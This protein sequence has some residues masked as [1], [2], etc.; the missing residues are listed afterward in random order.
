M[1]RDGRILHKM[2]DTEYQIFTFLASEVEADTAFAKDVGHRTS[3]WFSSN[4]RPAI[5][6]GQDEDGQL[7]YQNLAMLVGSSPIHG[8]LPHGSRVLV[9]IRDPCSLAIAILC[10]L[11]AGCSPC[12]VNPRESKMQEAADTMGCVA[13]VLD[14]QSLTNQLSATIIYI[15]K[16]Q[17]G[18]AFEWDCRSSSN[19]DS[20]K[21][22]REP[23][24][25]RTAC[26]I[27]RTSGTTG[28]AKIVPI[29]AWQLLYNVKR[30]ARSMQLTR[31]DV[32]ICPMPLFHIGGIA[33]PL[34]STL[35]SGGLLYLLPAFEPSSFVTEITNRTP[36]P[37]WY[38]AAPTI[39]KA[40]ALHIHSMG[41]KG[42]LAGHALRLVRSG[43]AHLPHKDA[44]ELRK[45][46]GPRCTI[47]PSC[48][49]SECMPVCS[50]HVGWDLA[51]PDTVGRP[52]GPS[53]AIAD[54]DTGQ[55]LPY[56]NVGE[57]LIQGPGV[58]RAYEGSSQTTNDHRHIVMPGLGSE[59]QP[60][61][62]SLCHKL[63]EILI[64]TA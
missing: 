12:P 35:V 15:L 52:I 18:M 36:K 33:C 53:L 61:V 14:D 27:L 39:H 58:M 60:K 40:L 56:G 59:Q 19:Q 17:A 25:Q 50:V 31:E 30:L 8:L 44:Q 46:F 29:E 43:A 64:F 54:P 6:G 3:T 42:A 16:R 47:M 10:I 20:K 48:S 28:C 24:G 26:L 38:Y 2:A 63:I 62:C 45:I 4:E 41:I 55:V 32:C 51:I 7:T 22:C 23:G 34:L 9:A 5:R 21:N 57:I 37:T 11:D 1:A 13:V 49:M